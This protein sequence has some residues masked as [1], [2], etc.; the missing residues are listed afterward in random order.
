MSML[1]GLGLF[2]FTTKMGISSGQM[3]S[4]VKTST[5]FFSEKKSECQCNI[6]IEDL[7]AH[8]L[9]EKFGEVRKEVAKCK[10]VEAYKKNWSVYVVPLEETKAKTSCKTLATFHRIL[11]TLLRSSAHIHSIDEKV[12]QAVGES[13]LYALAAKKEE[14]TLAG[15]GGEIVRKREYWDEIF[16]KLFENK[17]RPLSIFSIGGG[18]GYD[19]WAI[20]GLFKKEGFNIQPP[21]IVDP[22][23]V[24]GYFSKEVAQERIYQYYVQYIQD[25]FEKNYKRNL[26]DLHLFHIGTTLNILPEQVAVDVLKITAKNMRPKDILSVLLV[27]EEQFGKVEKEKIV[28]RNKEINAQGL[29]RFFYQISKEPYKTVIS[30]RELFKAFMSEIGLEGHFTQYDE[31]Q[32]K[33]IAYKSIK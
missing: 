15:E 9:Y 11:P 22:N 29:S 5:R 24:A 6:S 10:K 7:E 31:G 33:F 21:N 32:V 26:D 14:V 18:V 23:G 17:H 13:V 30:D 3:L 20:V 28:K 1:N 8:T 4:L 12:F 19:A 2:R 25:Y 27:D 16:E